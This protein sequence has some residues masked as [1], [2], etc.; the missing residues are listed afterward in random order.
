GKTL[1]PG[2]YSLFVDLAQGE[3]GPAWTL[4]VS[5]QPHQESFSRDEEVAT[6]GSY[7]YDP[8]YDVVR[9]PMEV[10]TSEHSLDQF[11]IV[12][13]DVTNEGGAIAMGWGDTLAVAPFGLGGG[14]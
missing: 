6:W 8:K 3:S 10:S 13:L 2:E 4:I 12:F 1:E 7:R 9:V 11:T 14:E 5:S